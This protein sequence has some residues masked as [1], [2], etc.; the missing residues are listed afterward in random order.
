MNCSEV[1]DMRFYLRRH[2][3]VAGYLILLLSVSGCATLDF[4]S[5][6]QV[7]APGGSDREL[8][9]LAD[10]AFALKKYDDGRKHLQRLINQFPESELVP[11]AR[12][13]V[14]RTYFDEKR[15]D[16][17]RAEYQRFIELFPQHE[18]LDEAQYY[19]ALSYFRQI[20]KV[21]RDQ[22]MTRKAVKEFRTLISEYRSSQFVPDAQA[23]LT[24][25]QRQLANREL[26]VGK[27]YFH[28]AAYGAAISRFESVLKEFPGFEYDDQA[29]YYLGESLWELEQK[30]PAK[31]AFQRL[32]AEFPDSDMTPQ[33]AKRIG[34]AFVQ[35]PQRTKP[36]A[37][38][39]SNARATMSDTMSE[40]KDSILD[41]AIWAPALP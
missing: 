27:F 23:M 13:I 41:S 5:P 28:R 14:G 16:E 38:F 30:E 12:L 34:V 15:Y 22:T 7:E 36:S 37:S 8:M 33:A 1:L 18:Q 9:S 11:T 10:T 19:T 20:E 4:F 2:L 29:L 24:E 32:I 40:L 35:N 3:L 25:S 31:A 17:A 26:F 39:L 21:D 6:K